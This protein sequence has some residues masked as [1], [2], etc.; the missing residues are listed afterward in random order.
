M[1]GQGI[2]A[3]Q[4]LIQIGGG[5]KWDDDTRAYQPKWKGYQP[6]YDKDSECNQG[7]EQTAYQTAIVFALKAEI[8][9]IGDHADQGRHGEQGGKHQRRNKDQWHEQKQ[10]RHGLD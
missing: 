3:E 7:I 5:N 4:A 1:L 9:P 8:A 6:Y 2:V 10:M